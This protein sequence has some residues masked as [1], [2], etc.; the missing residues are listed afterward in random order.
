M[1]LLSTLELG[2]IRMK[3]GAGLARKE[4]ILPRHLSRPLGRGASEPRKRPIS[5]PRFGTD[6]QIAF[7]LL[8]LNC[9]SWGGSRCIPGWVGVGKL[10]KYGVMNNPVGTKSF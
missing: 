6:S 4:A 8:A 5:Q 2:V 1:R 7:S 9:S 10:S 3:Q